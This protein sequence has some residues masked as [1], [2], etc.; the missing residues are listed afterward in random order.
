M[1]HFSTKDAKKIYINYV[2]KLDSVLKME[3]AWPEFKD[4]W[5]SI[6]KL[7]FSEFAL[8]ILNFINCQ[9]A[10]FETYCTSLFDSSKSFQQN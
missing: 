10:M 1:H 2:S 9:S 8:K 5:L 4:F 3:S 6:I 7:F